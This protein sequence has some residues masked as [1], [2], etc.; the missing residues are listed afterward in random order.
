MRNIFIRHYQI[1][2]GWMD[3]FF[4]HLYY[5][6]EFWLSTSCS[7]QNSP[8]KANAE[9]R[10]I[11]APLK[12]RLTLGLKV[13]YISFKTPPLSINARLSTI[14]FMNLFTNL[15]CLGLVGHKSVK[16]FCS[17]FNFGNR[18]FIA[19]ILA[20]RQFLVFSNRSQNS[21]KYCSVSIDLLPKAKFSALL[22]YIK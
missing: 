15:V 10:T 4:P 5:Q 1:L 13:C 14:S 21:R 6:N 19:D 7:C 17:G 8:F 20:K 3:L 18:G 9:K 22:L 12:P 11:S 16:N 2:L